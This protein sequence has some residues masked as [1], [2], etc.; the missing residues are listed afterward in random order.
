MKQSGLSGLVDIKLMD[1]RDINGSFDKIA[2]IEM[3]EAV[4]E[5]YWPAYFAKLS[6]VLKPGGKAALQIITIKEELFASYRGRADFIQRYIFP[7]GMLPSI[8]R[9]KEEVATAGLSWGKVQTFGEHYA[10][11]L[12]VWAQRFTAQWEEIRT[13]GF[14]ERFK[15]L[16]KF[17][18][19]Y[20]E[21]GFRTARTDVLQV[22]LAKA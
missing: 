10:A 5:R 16:W 6:S 11:T 7:G 14:D 12:S 2:S 13:L 17:Y 18:L 22:A 8:A 20:C 3:F 19:S 1:Y 4:G 15:R 21:A 9:L